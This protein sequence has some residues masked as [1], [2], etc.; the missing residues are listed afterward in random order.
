MNNLEAF[1]PY[2]IILGMLLGTLMI[3]SVVWIWIKQQTFAFGGS[4]LTVFGVVLVGLSIWGTVTVKVSPD[5]A[6]ETT[7][8]QRVA[9]V[10]AAVQKVDARVEQAQ[11]N[12]ATAIK[13][14]PN[15]PAAQIETLQKQEQVDK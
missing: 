6:I 12:L 11:S 14:I 5:G 13:E 1:A 8:E 3:V 10:E 15:L 4:I 9:T 2:A 7:F